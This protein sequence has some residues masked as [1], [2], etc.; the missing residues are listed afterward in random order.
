MNGITSLAAGFL[1]AAGRRLTEGF[2][3][4]ATALTARAAQSLF[5]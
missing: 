4:N 1:F 5:I 2:A 3:S